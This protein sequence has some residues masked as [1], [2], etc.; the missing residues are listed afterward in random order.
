M[1]TIQEKTFTKKEYDKNYDHGY[2]FGFESGRLSVF[3]KQLKILYTVWSVHHVNS[4]EWKLGEKDLDHPLDHNTDKPLKIVY[5]YHWYD[6]DYNQH[7]CDLY[8][9]AK[10]NTIG[11]VWK[12]IDRLYMD[13]GLQGTDHRFIEDINI[14]D[15][16][17]KFYTGS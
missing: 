6:E 2:E 1:T 7:N 16:V 9:R 11:E 5:N 12:G 3:E 17:L 13:H 8:G 10:N 14:E 4:K 15:N